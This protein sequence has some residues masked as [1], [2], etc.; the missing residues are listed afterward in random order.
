[1]RRKSGIRTQP[2]TTNM[3]DMS[4]SEQVRTG[5]TKSSIQPIPS[6]TLAL[7]RPHTQELRCRGSQHHSPANTRAPGGILSFWEPSSCTAALSTLPPGSLRSTLAHPEATSPTTLRH[8]EM[9]R[10]KPRN[11]W[12]PTRLERPSQTPPQRLQAAAR[13]QFSHTARVVLPKPRHELYE[14]AGQ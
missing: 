8:Q 6:A 5:D 2:Q 1:M 13:E 9:H 10:K 4:L 3:S 14:A 7:T 11:L 12:I